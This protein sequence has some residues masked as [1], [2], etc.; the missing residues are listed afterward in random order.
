MECVVLEHSKVFICL[1]TSETVEY[2]GRKNFLR[3]K[4]LSLRKIQNFKDK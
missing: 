2:L 1:K 3:N 4:K